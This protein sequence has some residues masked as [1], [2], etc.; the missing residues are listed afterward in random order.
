MEQK[1]CLPLDEGIQ[2][3]TVSKEE[4]LARRNQ[5]LA[6]EQ[7]FFEWWKK[8]VAL[9][10]WR[11]FGDGTEQGFIN[12]TNKNDLPPLPKIIESNFGGFSHG[13]LIF[14]VSMYCFYN[15]YKGAELCTKAEIKSIGDLT[16]LDSAR[17]EVIAGLIITYCGW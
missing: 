3:I 1:N 8:G 11:Y 14:V 2:I 16:V 7:S 10:G 13:E 17:R 9:A 12:A 5:Y 15:D 4:Q 6:R